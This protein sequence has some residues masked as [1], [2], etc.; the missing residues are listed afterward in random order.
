MRLYRDQTMTGAGQ[1][2]GTQDEAN[3]DFGRGQW[4]LVEVPTDKAG[5]IAWL[6]ALGRATAATAPPPPVPAP[7]ARDPAPSYAQ[8]SLAL[9]DAWEAL[10]L[11]RKLHFAALAMEDARDLA[12]QRG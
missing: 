5:L 3:R 9:D 12:A 11:V 7:P 8:T 6:N 2:T 10:P 4:K 1:W